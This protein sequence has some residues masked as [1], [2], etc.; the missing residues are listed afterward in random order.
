[1][2]TTLNI[3]DELLVRAKSRAALERTTLTK[4]IEQGL[5]LRLREPDREEH[6]QE[7]QLPPPLHGMGG[8][9]PKIKNPASY[10]SILDF[11]DEESG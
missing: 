1:M 3:D 9:N 2:R 7:I 5:A 8:M 6:N 11:L 10:E 4:I